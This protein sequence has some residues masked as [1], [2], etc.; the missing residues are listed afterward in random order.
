V[1]DLETSR[2]GAPYIYDI[3]HLRVNAVHMYF[4]FATFSRN[5]LATLTLR[6]CLPSSS[7]PFGMHL[8]FSPF[9]A[10]PFSV[11][12]AKKYSVFYFILFRL[13]K[14]LFAKLS[15]ITTMLIIKV[16]TCWLILFPGY[17]NCSQRRMH[18]RNLRC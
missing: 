4:K 8:V 17:Y 10:W 11:L 18:F 2:M 13:M 1:C 9:A 14:T 16:W 6:F 12:A 3:S 7:R 5:T 15:V